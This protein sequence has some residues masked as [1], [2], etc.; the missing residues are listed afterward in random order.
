MS[1]ENF[2]LSSKRPSPYDTTFEIGL[3]LDSEYYGLTAVE[4]LGTKI[5]QPSGDVFEIVGFEDIWPKGQEIYWRKVWVICH[6]KPKALP[7]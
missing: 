6:E 4:L 3:P 5:I 2:P 7:L 1:Q